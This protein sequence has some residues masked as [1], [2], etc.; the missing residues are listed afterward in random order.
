MPATASNAA[1]VAAAAMK[2]SGEIHPGSQLSGRPAGRDGGRVGKPFAPYRGEK[3]SK[4]SN[5]S[6]R[7]AI[8]LEAEFSHA[9]FAPAEVV[10]H[11]VPQRSLHLRSE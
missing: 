1:A 7:A 6:V 8:G 5:W 10:R 3:A 9:T 4:L 2:K 11:F